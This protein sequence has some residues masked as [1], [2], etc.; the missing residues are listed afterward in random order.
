MKKLIAVSAL[1]LLCGSAFAQN[2]GAPAAAQSDMNKPG[3]AN[4][5]GSITKTA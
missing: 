3:M 2:T 5:K 1:T 4:D